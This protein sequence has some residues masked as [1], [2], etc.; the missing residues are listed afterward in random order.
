MQYTRQPKIHVNTSHLLLALGYR[1]ISPESE[2]I[3]FWTTNQT[4][5]IE[6]QSTLYKHRPHRPHRHHQAQHASELGTCEVIDL[7][8][9]DSD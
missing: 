1:S 7:T 6:L 8:Q 5:P 2:V 9:G 3:N 4:L